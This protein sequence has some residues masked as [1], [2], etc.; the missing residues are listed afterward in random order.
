MSSNEIWVE[1]H[2][3]KSIND[4]IGNQ[5]IVET[6][7]SYAETK[8]LPHLLFVGFPGTGKTSSASSLARDILGENWKMNFLELNASNDRGIA[9]VRDR[10]KEFSRMAP[11]GSNLKIIFLDECESLTTDA[12]NALRRII[13]QYSRSTRFILSC[14]S[15]SKIIDA[16]KSRCDIF[17]FNKIDET[18]MFTLIEKVS[19]AEQLDVDIDAYDIIISYADGDA[20]KAINVLQSSAAKSRKIT[21]SNI[22][23]PNIEQYSSEV[24]K[25]ID[26]AYNKKY[27]DARKRTRS[28]MRDLDVSAEKFVE[29]VH[30]Y[31]FV[32]N[33]QP[34]NW[35]A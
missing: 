9:V 3:P 34:I 35:L 30:R 28:F 14:N 29:E 12:Q 5:K 17:N 25:I 1:K 13:E 24:G 19:K 20:R 2:R 33:Y 27:D 6:L 22:H 31:S 8:N 26:L 16:I 21:K 15:S 11:M 10:I 7:K 4:I 18:S 23:V 32:V